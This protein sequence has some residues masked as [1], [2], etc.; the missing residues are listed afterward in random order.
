VL[1]RRLQRHERLTA[2]A[3]VRSLGQERALLRG[4]AIPILALVVAWAAGA[5][6]AD[7]IAAALYSTVAALVVFE[8]VAAVRSHASPAETALEVS[9][10]LGMGL[11]ILSLKIIL[12]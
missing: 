3:L 10:G 7:A 5:S 8:L 12:G 11:A 2:T 6:Q 1:G 4:A 9:V